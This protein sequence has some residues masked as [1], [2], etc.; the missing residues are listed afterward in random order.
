MLLTK[1]HETVMELAH[2]STVNDALEKDIL[3]HLN[4]VVARINYLE[5]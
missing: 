5:S 1:G 3:T 2:V 4:S